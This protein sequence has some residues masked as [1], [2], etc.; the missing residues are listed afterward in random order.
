MELHSPLRRFVS[1]Y[2]ELLFVVAA[3]IIGLGVQRPLAWLTVHQGLNVLLAALVFATA[4]T[5]EPAAVRRVTH[6]SRQLVAVLS[7]GSRSCPRWPGP[8]LVS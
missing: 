8:H 6:S 2:P 1:A 5:I 3:A 7:P 4:I